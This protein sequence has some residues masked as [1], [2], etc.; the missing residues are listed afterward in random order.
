MWLRW[1][2]RIWRCGMIADCAVYRRG[3]PG[4]KL[5]MTLGLPVYV[6]S[7]LSFHEVLLNTQ[8]RTRHIRV[9]SLDAQALRKMYKRRRRETRLTTPTAARS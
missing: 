4:G 5:K 3:A 2:M 1:D 6:P 9:P 8:I 7:S